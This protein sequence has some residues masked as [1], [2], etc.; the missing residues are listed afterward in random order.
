ME[1]GNP[2]LE[3]PN[4]RSSVS[5]L[6][7]N[8]LGVYLQGTPM[9]KSVRVSD[10]L[11]VVGNGRGFHHHVGELLFGGSN[12][13]SLVVTAP[14]VPQVEPSI[15]RSEEVG[16]CRVTMWTTFPTS[17]IVA[18]SSKWIGRD[19]SYK[20]TLN[21]QVGYRLVLQ[22]GSSQVRLGTCFPSGP[23]QKI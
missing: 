17:R 4:T 13:P 2:P 21:L 9:P 7:W 10:E 20:S 14:C 23:A 18:R 5:P 1:P 3:E 15:L 12:C 6:R 22:V 11:Q 8:R 16:C 19:L